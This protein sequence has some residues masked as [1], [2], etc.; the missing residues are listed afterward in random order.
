MRSLPAKAALAAF[1]T[2][3]LPYEGHALGLGTAGE[4]EHARANARA[5]GPLSERDVEL[6]E[7]WGCTSGTRMAVC[8]PRGYYRDDDDTPPRQRRRKHH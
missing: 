3:T 6:L 8:Q 7:R 5:G 4:L 1:V 2:L